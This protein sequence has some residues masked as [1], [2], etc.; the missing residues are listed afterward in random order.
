MIEETWKEGTF[1]AFYAGCE[2][3]V[4]VD[5]GCNRLVLKDVPTKEECPNFT[6]EPSA[7]PCYLG[8]AA[9]GGKLDI[10]GSG[11]ITS[12]DGI[13]T[14][15][16]HCPTAASNLLLPELAISYNDRRIVTWSDFDKDTHAWE[17]SQVLTMRSD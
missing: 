16:K 17:N 14:V 3:M 12:E 11:I 5:S 2:E 6:Y 10:A 1:V 4:A 8:T 15:Y 9:A 13:Q 7:V